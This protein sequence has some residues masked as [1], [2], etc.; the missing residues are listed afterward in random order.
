MKNLCILPVI[1]FMI[2]ACSTEKTSIRLL[3]DVDSY[4]ENYPDSA[5]SVL[6]NIDKSKLNSKEILAQYALLLSMALD[7]NYIDKTDFS[8]LQPAIDYYSKKGD[9]TDKLRTFYYQ[10]RIYDNS[11]N[12]DAAMES[13]VRGLDYGKTSND[14][15]TKARA[16]FSKAQIHLS[17]YEYNKYTENMLSAALFFKDK[18]NSSYFN[19]LCCAHNG[20]LLQNDTIGAARILNTLSSFA[21]YATQ[22][23]LSKFFELKISYA[24]SFLSDSSVLGEIDRY[25]HEVDYN[26]IHWITLAKAYKD[27]GKYREAL[28]AIEQHNKYNT[29]KDARYYAITSRIFENIGNTSE[30]LEHYKMYLKITDSLDMVVFRQDAKFI[31]ER[32]YQHMK[33]MEEKLQKQQ[34]IFAT[35]FILVILG[36]TILTISNKLKLKVAES[37]KYRM[38]CSQLELEKIKLTEIIEGNT[39]IDESTKKIIFN[40]IELLNSFLA[41]H[42]TDDE[43]KYNESQ[44]N[45]EKLINDRANFIESNNTAFELKYP[46]FINYLKKMGLSSIEISYCCLYALGL[47]G[48]DIGLYTKMSRHYIISSS[49]R[50][51]L[52]L[53]SNETNLNKYISQLLNNQ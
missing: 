30:A 21:S 36:T 5:L 4:I 3:N 28:W 43:R 18:N 44:H 11:G 33:I 22:I 41:A 38:H 10:G 46:E 48:K 15:L 6:E 53:K 7:K 39:I 12:N 42:I 23:Q 34:Y 26:N 49:I 19:S 20:Y 47:N 32:Y 29:R 9:A 37:E 35:L 52:G 51:K 14:S 27:V 45:L 25:L 8:I 40:R 13:Y 17:L 31:E 50:K 1:I 24:N 16:L 2:T